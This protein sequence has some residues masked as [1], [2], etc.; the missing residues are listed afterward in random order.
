M[1][2]LTMHFYLLS[3]FHLVTSLH[4]HTNRKVIFCLSKC[5]VICVFR[6]S[7]FFYKPSNSSL[8]NCIVAEP[9]PKYKG[10]LPTV[11]AGLFPLQERINA[12]GLAPGSCHRLSMMMPVV[13][14]YPLVYFCFYALV[15]VTECH[16]YIQESNR[17]CILQ[18]LDNKFR[19]YSCHFTGRSF[20]FPM[21]A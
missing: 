3:K 15:S 18:M 10:N 7:K 19:N 12:P 11:K 17:I 9:P 5:I 8:S 1:C 16:L 6:V 2:F 20:L 4:T 21:F 14:L 13:F